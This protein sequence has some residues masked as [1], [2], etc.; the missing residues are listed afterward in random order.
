MLKLFCLRKTYGQKN[1][2]CVK[3]QK[4]TRCLG[5]VCPALGLT[6]SWRRPLSYR[7]RFYML[8]A[9]VMKELNTWASGQLQKMLIT[10][11]L[12][13]KYSEN[14][15]KIQ[16]ETPTVVSF[17]RKSCRPRCRRLQK[18]DVIW[19]LFQGFLQIFFKYLFYRAPLIGIQFSRIYNPVEYVR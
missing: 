6:L 15:P 11:V 9:S 3:K 1:V 10:D 2:V 17:F 19:G 18:N 7:N 12:S 4:D 5:S 14:G 16:K 8:K 13:N